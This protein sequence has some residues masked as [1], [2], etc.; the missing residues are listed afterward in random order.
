[1]MILLATTA[2]C[3]PRCCDAIAERTGH[4]VRHA[5]QPSEVRSLLKSGDYQVLVLDQA[6]LD[7]QPAGWNFLWQ[8]G[9]VPV[10][11]TVN[12]GLSGME[13]VVRET[14]AAL[15]RHRWEV[16]RARQAAAAALA[17]EVNAALTGILLSSELALAEPELPPAAADNLRSVQELAQRL[18]VRLESRAG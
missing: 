16:A 3:A 13:R 6:L 12:L 15:A 1:M 10:S 17:G 11:I 18:R 5:W 9:D 2:E 7:L 8:C 14:E 4:S